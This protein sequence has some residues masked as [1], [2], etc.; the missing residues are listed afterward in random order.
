[1]TRQFRAS[2]FVAVTALVGL[3]FKPCIGTMFGA[4][5]EALACTAAA[6][7]TAE[8]DPSG[9]V[10]AASATGPTIGPANGAAPAI[11]AGAARAGGGTS[12]RPTLAS[13][14]LEAG[15]A[16]GRARIR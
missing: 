1:M 9:H 11:A 14:A 6:C 3:H 5:S 16:A 8:D 13:L 12:A 4:V 7:D 10:L 2:L 15:G